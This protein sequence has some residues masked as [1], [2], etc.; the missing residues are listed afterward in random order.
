MIIQQI[1]QISIVE[2]IEYQT[3]KH[4]NDLTRLNDIEG[5]D[6]SKTFQISALH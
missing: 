2:V 4:V 6:N 3:V 1:P 5:H